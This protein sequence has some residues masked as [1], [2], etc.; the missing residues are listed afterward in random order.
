MARRFRLLAAALA[1]TFALVPLASPALAVS[2]G[3]E[4]RIGE[5]AAKDVDAQNVLIT[6]PIL[7][8]WVNSTAANLSQYR[9]RPDINYRFKIID[10]NDINAFALPGGFIYLNFGM[11]NFVNSDDELA[12]VMG[13][14]MGHVE[15]RHSI[16]MNA[17]AQVLNI[18]IGVLSIASPFVYRFGNL[19]GDL[20]LYKLSRV[21][22][23]QADQYGLLLMTRA[24]YDPNAMVSFME[25]LDKM[26]TSSGGFN[27]YFETH[28]DPKN[29]VAHL[30]GYPQL[31]KTD[32]NQLLA[33]AVHDEDEGRYAYA[34]TKIEAVLKLDP[35][36]EL[37]TIHKGQLQLALGSLDKSQ[38]TLQSVANNAK[39]STDAQNAAHHALALLQKADPP[40]DLTHPN[41][42]PLRKALDAS[43]ALAKA[44]QPVLEE[45]AKIGKEDRRKFLDRVEQLAYQLPNFGNIDVRPNSRLDGVLQD[46]YHI[47]KDLNVIDDKTNYFFASSPGLQKDDAGV[48]NELAAGLHAANPT[49]EQLRLFPYYREMISEMDASSNNIVQ[50][51]T[52]SRGALALGWQALPA[53]DAYFRQLSRVSPDFGGDISARNAEQ[54]KPLAKAAQ[55]QLDAA[56][57]AAEQAQT[58]YFEAQA[59]QLQTRITLLGV[60]F[61]E[62]RYQTLQHSIGKRL[63]VQAPSYDEALKLGESPG[64]L[65]T[66]AWLAAEEKV[67]V[68]TVIA[69]QRAA[70]KPLVDM[71]IEK[72]L[73]QESLE[74]TLGLWWEGYAEKATD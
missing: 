16:T 65:A 54:L 10:T 26:H 31:S 32:T 41:L 40:I 46:L 15:R 72:G 30:L 57:N 36:N 21:D 34:L 53:L 4:I 74:V 19:I 24:G 11:L 17:K 68:R 5:N 48:L 66:A 73:A 62:A 61:P 29:R 44:N 3:S 23:L 50:G 52:A 33:Q 1:A 43:Q 59:R 39:A 20:S 70:H 7:T 18:L 9:A 2:T 8:N 22:E 6:D 58:F 47:S 37:A 60:G 42:D 69:E 71:A 14:E 45:R 55:D 63:G 64:Y 35:N 49:G 56:A 67:P 25:R 12:G 13:H 38:T 27:K 28:P 51:A